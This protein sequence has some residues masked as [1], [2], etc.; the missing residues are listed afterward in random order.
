MSLDG[1]LRLDPVDDHAYDHD[2][3]HDHDHDHVGS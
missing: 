2:H 1:L 3:V